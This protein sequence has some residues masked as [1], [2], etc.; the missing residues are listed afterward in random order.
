MFVERG[1]PR[2]QHEVM[3]GVRVLVHVDLALHINAGLAQNGVRLLMA[4][5][6]VPSSR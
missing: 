5:D 3:L 4:V 6:S 2:W 1:G